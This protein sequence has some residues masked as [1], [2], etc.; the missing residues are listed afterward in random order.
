MT[1]T[2]LL[3]EISK[4]V[5]ENKEE[6]VELNKATCRK[7]ALPY[8]RYID[9]F[10]GEKGVTEKTYSQIWHICA[11]VAAV[12]HPRTYYFKY[13]PQGASKP[14]EANDFEYSLC[15]VILTSDW[16]DFNLGK[17]IANA[18]TRRL[19]NPDL[20]QDFKDMVNHKDQGYF[21]A[22]LDE[23]KSWKDSETLL[24]N[25]DTI[26]W[27]LI[28]P[29]MIGDLMVIPEIKIKPNGE[30]EKYKCRTRYFGG[31]DGK[32]L[33]PIIRTPAQSILT[34]S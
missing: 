15:K 1:L 28:D 5:N 31:I 6:Y 33:A 11:V 9:K 32:I 22:F 26:D 23:V 25:F 20:P 8:F 21:L 18:A 10:F 3:E 2:P 24:P 30:I 13:Y 34:H 19:S 17:A 29:T 7:D 27:S 4:E 16:T 12:D 14:S